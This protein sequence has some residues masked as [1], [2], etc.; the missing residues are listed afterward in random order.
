MFFGGKWDLEDGII[1]DM[2]FWESFEEILLLSEKVEVIGFMFLLIL[3]VG[4]KVIFFIGIIF[5]D[6]ELVFSE[7]EIESLFLVLISYFL[8]V[9]LLDFMIWE[10]FGV[11][12]KVF[13][14]YYENYIIWGF[15]VYFIIDC[16]NW[17]F[18]I[19]FEFVM[20]E[21]LLEMDVK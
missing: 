5:Y 10:Y 7:Y 16:F 11:W 21:L 3:K 15:I 2:A 18:D 17:I 9:L 19:G 6:L 1:L 8:E 20:V 12:Y 13:C 4:L 14:Y